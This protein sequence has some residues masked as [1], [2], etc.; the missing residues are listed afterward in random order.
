MGMFTYIYF[1]DNI[2]HKFNVFE[3]KLPLDKDWQTKDIDSCMESYC[4]KQTNKGIK[5]FYMQPLNREEDKQYWIEYTDSEIISE[6][7]KNKHSPFFSLWRREKGDG[8]FLPEA[9]LIQ[10]RKFKDM[11]ELPHQIM[12]VYTGN[13]YELEIKFTDGVAV[14]F[15]RL[16]YKNNWDLDKKSEWI[17]L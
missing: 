9:Y 3:D 10:N 2:S 12:R 13:W 14:E 4:L 11:G 1:D 16:W 7:E 6:N 17:K 5:L 15:R 8:Y